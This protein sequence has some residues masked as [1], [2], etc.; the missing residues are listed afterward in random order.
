MMSAFPDWGTS[1]NSLPMAPRE[2]LVQRLTRAGLIA[3][4]LGLLGSGIA[5][6]LLVNFSLREQQQRSAEQSAQLLAE[7]LAPALAFQDARA[8]EQA[9]QAFKL[10]PD[11]KA[12]EVWSA[13]GLGFAHWRAPG[14]LPSNAV[15]K[16]E[17]KRSAWSLQIQVP[18][19]LKQERLGWLRWRESFDSLYATLL[20]LALG[21]LVVLGISLLATSLWLGRVQR[22][23]LKPLVALSRLAEEVAF[24]QDYGLRATVGRRDEVGRLAERFNALL[25]RIE[26]WHEDLHQQL[27]REQAAGLQYQQQAYRDALTQL[28]N[29][30]AFE[31]ELERQLV[32][33]PRQQRRIAL[34]FIDLD[35][36]KWVNDNLGHAA[37]DLVL[38]T[39][40]QRMTSRLR[41]S[42]ALFRL[43]GDEFALLVTEVGD[44]DSVRL[45]AGRLIAAVREPM[46]VDG[47]P[48]P[49][50]ATVGIA[51]AP[52][53]A[54]DAQTLLM[55][56]DAAMYA[57]KRAGKNTF[58]C[59]EDFPP[60]V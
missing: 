47:R 4:F 44:P 10:R 48:V 14:V 57:A 33:L 2:S 37:G 31:V 45:L 56:A 20:R 26:V 27:E 40:A 49:V 29:R 9:L 18:I 58:R 42:D 22:Q 25:R 53:D 54:R 51:F 52:D 6:A 24:S 17:V 43:G 1:E 15:S 19:L 36:F 5:S 34:L 50:G 30:L 12:L 23:A 35:Q 13:D 8:A 7:S 38:N 16:A 59:A 41:E 46:A 60:L 21:G 28:P 32:E 39:V 55:R 11:L 3:L